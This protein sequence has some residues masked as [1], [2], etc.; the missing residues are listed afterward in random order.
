MNVG[1]PIFNG[2]DVKRAVNQQ[3]LVALQSRD[4]LD[5]FTI[6]FESEKATTRVQIQKAMQRFSYADANLKLANNNIELLHEAFVN[7]V[8]DNQDMILGE[9]DLYDNQARYFNELLQLMLSEIEG[10]RVVGLFNKL[11]G[12]EGD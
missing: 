1:I 4:Y 8:A 9:N 7:G 10:Q 11:A 6:Q 12:L 2:M 3:K 5:Q